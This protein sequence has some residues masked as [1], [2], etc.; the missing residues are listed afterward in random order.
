MLLMEPSSDVSV[1]SIDENIQKSTLN[2][3]RKRKKQLY[4][5]LKKQ[6]EFYLS[7]ANLRKDRF[8]GHLMQTTNCIGVD[9]FLNCNK[10][11]NLTTNPEDIVK[12]IE[13]SNILGVSD[14]KT[15][16]YRIQP[17][18]DK[19]PED[20]ERCTVYVEQLPLKADHD[21]VKSMFEK[22]GNVAY[23]SLPKFKSGTIKRFAF[24]EFEDEESAKKVVEEHKKQ[25]EEPKILPEDL[26]SIITF[27]EDENK[28][29]TGIINLERKRKHSINNDSVKDKK[30]KKEV[31][32]VSALGNKNNKKKKKKDKNKKN[33]MENE[34]KES[35]FEI[36]DNENNQ[37]ALLNEQL[38][39]SI[40]KSDEIMPSDDDKKKC[41]ESNDVDSL[42]KKKKR[43]RNKGKKGKSNINTTI[44]PSL[45]IMSK[46]EWRK[47]RNQFLNMQRQKMSLL[48]AQLQHPKY[49]ENHNTNFHKNTEDNFDK[50]INS[51]NLQSEVVK[52]KDIRVKYEPGVILKITFSNPIESDKIFKAEA[53]TDSNV[54][55]VDVVNNCE[56]YIRCDCQESAQKIAEE[57]R[58]PQTTLLKGEEEKLYW[59]KI[60]RDREIKFT[61][62]KNTKKPRGRLK[63][64]N[65]A[66]KRL[67]QHV[68]F[69]EEND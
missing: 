30:M 54:K 29:D 6:M 11:K 3:V 4:A 25:H 24:V 43:K 42:I 32:K 69:T 5:D 23:I 67:A 17:I 36:S 27:N 14:C 1:E 64:I 38:D 62:Q 19:Q 57:N 21:W 26:Q 39:S 41:N 8:F 35:S 12:A 51:V 13:S 65:K 16:V 46:T 34:Q 60:L 31:P 52:S 37:K 9:T 48:K 44:T 47:L 33:N 56:A 50:N 68:T 28:K 59:E 45:R 15:K 20:I 55:F 53:K 58:W 61:I 10:I 7:D 22:Y 49:T 63:L 40:E 18:E 2:R 66:E